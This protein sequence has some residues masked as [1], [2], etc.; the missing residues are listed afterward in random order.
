MRFPTFFATFVIAGLLVPGTAH[1]QTTIR[2][3]T[4]TAVLIQRGAAYGRM[5]RLS[6]DALFCVYSRR[7]T[8][9]VRRSADRGKTWNSEIVAVEYPQGQATNGELLVRQDGHVHIIYN[10]RPGD[11]RSPFAI[12]ICAS[13][14]GGQTWQGHRRI[15][16]AGTQFENGCWEPAAVELASGEIQLFF[17]DEGPYRSSDEQ[18]ITRLRSLDGGVT[19]LEPEAVSFRP[20]HRDGMPVPLLLAGGNRIALAIEDNGLGGAF[21]PAIVLLSLTDGPGAIP[22]GASDIRRQPA[23]AE[24]LPDDVYAG[25]P[26]VV[27]FPTGETVLSVQSSEGR[28]VPHDF[29]N[30]RMVVYVGDSTAHHFAARSV[31]FEALT[32]APGLWNALFVKDAETITAISGTTVNGVRGLWAIDGRIERHTET[33]NGGISK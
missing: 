15:Y 13:D 29:S 12:G 16:T 33:R 23:L 27:Q 24:P 2:W 11:G 20:G 10:E 5:A 9:Y 21:K 4:D 17:A 22:V 14:D 26:Y 6:D 25:A 8:V 19:W 32:D 18:Q 28:G 1:S 30:S 31:P 7:G 3:Q